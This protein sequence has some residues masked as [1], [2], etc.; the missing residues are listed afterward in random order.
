MTLSCDMQLDRP[1]GQYQAGETVN[2]NIYLTLPERQ[3]IKA[4]A[5][6]ANGYAA[7]SWLKPQKQKKKN[8][9]PQEQ[10]VVVI[11]KSKGKQKEPIAFEQRVDYLASTSY[12]IGSEAARHKIMDAGVYHFAFSVP[13]PENCP[14][15][16]EGQYGHIRY[17]LQLVLL[18]GGDT[19]E[20]LVAHYRTLQVVQHA[21][22]RHESAT[23][24]EPLDEQQLE[25]TP[26]MKFWQRPLL[27][28]LNIP[29]RGYAPGEGIS[30]HVRLHNPQQ[31]MLS[32]LIYKLNLLTTYTGQQRGKPKRQDT[33]L[34]RR[35]LLSSVHQLSNTPRSELFQH[36][37]TLTVPQMPPSLEVVSCQCLQLSYEVEVVAK[38][39][40]RTRF[41]MAQVPVC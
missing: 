29:R 28:E 5:L 36:L 11:D 33:K 34:E 16:Y 32:E 10:N 2:G 37:H 14:S 23:L 8:Q 1:N 39:T 26:R 40:Q 9:Q 22:L 41:I 7:C 35:N 17:T 25:R 13:L 31:L 12:F 20:R 15:S 21:D 3:L 6:E 4:I 27:L 18:L 38:T 30:V 24:N 19:N